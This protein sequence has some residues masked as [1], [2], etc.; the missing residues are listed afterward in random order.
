MLSK[1]QSNIVSSFQRLARVAAC[2]PCDVLL[3]A[4]RLCNVNALKFPRVHRVTASPVILFIPA[5]I[6]LCGPLSRTVL[7]ARFYIVLHCIF[8]QFFHFL[9]P[10]LS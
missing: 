3:W 6:Q 9:F 1:V 2:R 5:P 10:A 4:A 8:S 7:L